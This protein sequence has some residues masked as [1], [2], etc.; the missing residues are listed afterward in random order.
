MGVSSA[1]ISTLVANAFYLQLLWIV[2]PASMR[3]SGARRANPCCFGGEAG[4][5]LKKIYG[6]GGLVGDVSACSGR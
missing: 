6:L 3:L 1:T 4:D 5:H 2:V